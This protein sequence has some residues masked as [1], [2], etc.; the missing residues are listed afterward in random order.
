V[1]AGDGV[2][3]TFRSAVHFVQRA[4]RTVHFV[5]ARGAPGARS[6]RA[7][8]RF[9][10]P[11][12]RRL[13][14]SGRFRQLPRARRALISFRSRLGRPDRQSTDIEWASRRGGADIPKGALP[15]PGATRRAPARSSAGVRPGWPFLRR[16]TH[17]LGRRL[18]AGGEYGRAAR[19]RVRAEAEASARAGGESSRATSSVQRGAPDGDRRQ[20]P[21]AR[22][23]TRRRTPPQIERTNTVVGTAVPCRLSTCPNSAFGSGWSAPRLP[24]VSAVR[25]C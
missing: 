23:P 17:E 10:P 9:L 19:S 5:C 18:A 16:M 25:S 24:P 8:A 1:G 12:G 4:A 13:R 15:E 20:A 14:A 2:H 22:A 11:C 21:D 6:G 3:E 7:P